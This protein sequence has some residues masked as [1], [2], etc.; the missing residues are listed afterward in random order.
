MQLIRNH[1]EAVVEG[2]GVKDISNIIGYNFRLGE[3]E[4]AIGIEQFKKLDHLV[5]RRVEIANILSNG[6]SDLAGLKTPI[7]KDGFTHSFYVYGL[8]YDETKTGIHRDKVYEALK[9]EGVPI[10]NCYANLHLLP[11]YQ[12]R[13]A[14]GTKG[15]PWNS[16][17]Y[18]GNVSYE[19][20]ICPVA[21]NL[22]DKTFLKIPIC[23]YEFNDNEVQK[24]IKAF[25]KVWDQLEKLK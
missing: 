4:A 20:G 22:N 25:N 24:V 8:T 12:T 6:L 2:K 14:Y 15:F 1:G 16:E 9:M 21:E 3:I 17:F 19:K 23:D 10:V 7:T 18:R 13:I 11:M 5:S